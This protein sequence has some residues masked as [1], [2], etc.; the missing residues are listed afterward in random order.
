MWAKTMAFALILAVA[1]AAQDDEA[2][3][4][5]EE[6]KAKIADFKTELKGAKTD[7]DITRAIEGLGALQ[8]PKILIELKAY[9]GRTPDEVAAA[10]EEIGK[11]KKDKDAA[12]ILLNAAGGRK[13]KDS[14]VKCLRYAGDTE[15]K[16]IVSKL[17]GYFRHKEVDVAKESVDSCA[18]VKSK[19][20]IEPLLGLWKELDGIKE[21]KAD[22]GGGLGVGGLGGGLTG[23]GGV[24]ASV[25]QEQLKRKH[26]LTPAVESALSK[27]TGEDFKD[28]RA[29]NEWWR[30]NKAT[31][32][33]LE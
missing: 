29:A 14:I 13:D 19:D 28:L 33:D 17:T 16:G 12:D 3:K 21:E 7:K 18:K 30:K 15:F 2:K 5:E 1:A 22:K 25:Q 31:F 9:L 20:A 4:K 10:A 23:T 6:A 11:Y 32:K 26:D 24:G 8:H 27:I